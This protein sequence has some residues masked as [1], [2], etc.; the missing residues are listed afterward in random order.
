M[1]RRTQNFSLLRLRN[2]LQRMVARCTLAP[3]FRAFGRGSVLLSPR[4]IE[5][6]QRIRIGHRVYIADGAVLAAV[7]HTGAENCELVIGDGC[8]LSRDVHLYATASIVLEPEVLCAANVYVAD[9]SHAFGHRSTPILEQE[10]R[11]LRPVRIGRGAWLGQ[12]V[13]VIGASIGKGSVVG[14]NSVVL[15][16]VPDDCVAVGAPARV[17]RR[18]GSAACEDASHAPARRSQEKEI[19]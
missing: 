15:S 18:L 9:N 16:D 13:C 8:F 12:N 10:I 7:P 11:Q 6:I 5:G 17:V 2:L 4:S 14:A 3:F 19:P 1:P